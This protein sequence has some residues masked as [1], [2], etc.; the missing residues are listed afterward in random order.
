MKRLRRTNAYSIGLDDFRLV[1]RPTP[2]SAPTAFR[3]WQAGRNPADDGGCLFSTRS[4]DLLM[5]EQTVRGNLY[6]IDFD[7]LSLMSDRPADAGRAAGWHRLAVRPGPDGAPE[8]WAVD[9]EWCADAKAGLEEQPPRWRY[10]SPA[11]DIDA[12]TREVVSYLNTALCINPKTW[13]NNQLATRTAGSTTM[14]KAQRETLAVLAAM[15]SA[16]NADDGTDESKAAAKAMYTMHGGSEE[17]ESLKKMAAGDDDDDDD[18]GEERRDAEG[19]EGDGEKPVTD[20]EGEEEAEEEKPK[21]EAKAATRKGVAPKLGESGLLQTVTSLAARI[22]LMERARAKAATRRKAD[23]VTTIL[24]SRKDL[25]ETVRASLVG[26]EPDQVRKI[27]DALPKADVS[28]RESVTATRG[29]KQGI[30][31]TGASGRARPEVEAEVDRAMRIAPPPGPVVGFGEVVNG[32][33]VFHTRRPT[34]F[35]AMKRTNDAAQS[36]SGKAG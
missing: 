21:T 20:A 28:K 7:H 9:V 32:A 29:E 18:D 5:T 11:F 14:T 30:A 34:E 2:T 35:R 27:V 16:M 4:A 24:N 36:A 13:N 6:S 23:R 8:L 19:D 26:L 15:S 10:F 22:D 33:R 25:S 12:D 3:I 1:E 31:T 17:H